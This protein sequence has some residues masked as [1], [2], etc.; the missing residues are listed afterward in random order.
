MMRRLLLSLV[1]CL[2]GPLLAL[3]AVVHVQTQSQTVASGTS[4]SVAITTTAGNMVVANIASYFS[5]TNLTQ[6][7][8]DTLTQAFEN[9]ANAI[10]RQYYDCSVAGGAT[11]FTF[12]TTGTAGDAL[13]LLVSEF[14]GNA[15][16]L[17]FDVSAQG[18]YVASGTAFATGT[19]GTTAQADEVAV[20]FLNTMGAGPTALNAVSNAYVVPTNG[21]LTNVG[22]SANYAAVAYGILTA[23][24]TTTTTFTLAD[25]VGGVAMVGTYKGGEP[26]VPSVA[27]RPPIR[28]Q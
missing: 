2:S 19:T 9:T 28:F 22:G 10:S 21:G 7:A 16:T 5:A 12:T 18:S 26:A 4:I 6:T 23:T 3:G 13:V 17:C 27:R 1:L 24:G 25:A 8:G 20:A 11:T 14:S 15:A